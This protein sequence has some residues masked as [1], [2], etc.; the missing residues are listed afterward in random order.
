MDQ[1]RSV[2]ADSIKNNSEFW[3]RNTRELLHWQH[4]FQMVSDCD[5]S[6]G[7]ISWFL[8]GKLNACENCVDRHVTEKGDQTAIIWES[9]E[10]GQEQKITYREL[11][12][13]VSRL[14]A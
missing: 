8:G 4:D 10:P 9:D 3:D 2:Y 11:Q 1:Y 5:F 12:R 6:E 14:E 7:L 13:K